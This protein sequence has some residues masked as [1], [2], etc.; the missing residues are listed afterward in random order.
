MNT[1]KLKNILIVVILYI[2]TLVSGDYLFKKCEIKCT[3]GLVINIFD[4]KDINKDK[5]VEL[6]CLL[7]NGEVGI[8]FLDK[9]SILQNFISLSNDRRKIN[10][11]AIGDV[12]G[13]KSDVIVAVGGKNLC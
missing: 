3:P 5:I 9:S 10:D 1:K 12:F 11:I 2:P 8:R 7:D 6:A 13:D 4:A